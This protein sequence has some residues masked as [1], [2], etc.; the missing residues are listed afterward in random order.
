MSHRFSS[1]HQDLF[2]FSSAVFF[3]SVWGLLFIVV[4]FDAF[5]FSL[6]FHSYLFFA[7][8]FPDVGGWPLCLELPSAEVVL[9]ALGVINPKAE[10]SIWDC[11]S[12]RGTGIKRIGKAA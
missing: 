4:A 11:G 3:Y 5:F 2:F 6:F 8:A 12:V 10:I 7:Y 1:P 9:C